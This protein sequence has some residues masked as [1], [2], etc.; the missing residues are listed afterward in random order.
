MYKLIHFKRTEVKGKYK[1][2]CS[3]TY[4]DKWAAYADARTVFDNATDHDYAG[5]MI[6]NPDGSTLCRQL[7]TWCL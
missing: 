6:K 7:K 5:F 1:D 3:C 2:I 4:A